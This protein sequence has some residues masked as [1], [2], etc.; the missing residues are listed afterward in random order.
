M[1]NKTIIS[2]GFPLFSLFP[3]TISSI[4]SKTTSDNPY[5]TPSTNTSNALSKCPNSVRKENPQ[6]VQEIHWKEVGRF[7][8]CLTCIEVGKFKC[9]DNCKHLNSKKVFEAR[10]EAKDIWW[11][12]EMLSILH[13]RIFYVSC[14]AISEMFQ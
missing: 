12:Q 4:S 13:L 11:L 3:S 6:I 5:K 7:Q 8:T 14:K 10:K 1:S 2:S 9:K